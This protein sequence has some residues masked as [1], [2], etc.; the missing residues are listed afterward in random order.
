MQVFLFAEIFYI[1]CTVTLKLSITILLLRIATKKG[2]YRIIILSTAI[3]YFICGL[4]F[5]FIL[6]FQCIPVSSYWDL[7]PF[8]S[9]PHNCIPR[10]VFAKL[11]QVNAAIS[12]VTDGVFAIVPIIMI[13]QTQ[14]NLRMKISA[15]AVLGL[16]L[17]TV[18]VN[19][20]RFFYIPGLGT[21]EDSTCKSPY[22]S[23]CS[24]KPVLMLLGK[25][26]FFQSRS[27]VYWKLG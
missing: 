27:R 23:Q 21:W 15:G 5:F 9:A 8:P 20:A 18:I 13:S 16:G 19:I 2:L 12:L 26:I 4:V 6:M 25:I 7:A 10:P 1:T 22:S 11:I 14:M 3:F 17:T 24:F